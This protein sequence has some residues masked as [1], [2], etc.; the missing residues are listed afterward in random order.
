[1][2]K[3]AP[4][5]ISDNLVEAISE[6]THRKKVTASLL[7][8]QKSW[9]SQ[10]LRRRLAGNG[11]L[12]HKGNILRYTSIPCIELRFG[13]QNMV[14][15]CLGFI[16]EHNFAIRS[17]QPAASILWFRLVLLLSS[18]TPALPLPGLIWVFTLIYRLWRYFF[19]SVLLDSTFRIRYVQIIQISAILQDELNLRKMYS[20]AQY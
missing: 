16:V 5:D 17:T 2:R 13:E 18:R 15:V 12:H 3:N 9:K 7:N 8:E 11:T 19:F 10:K 4:F 14:L 1:M 6:K 20:T